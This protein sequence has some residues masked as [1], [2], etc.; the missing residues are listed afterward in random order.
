VTSITSS[1]G[2]IAPDQIAPLL[3]GRMD[4]HQSQPRVISISQSTEF[5]T[6]YSIDEIHTLADFAHANDMKL[7]MDGARLSNATASL[8]CSLREITGEAGVDILSFGGTKNGMMMGEAVIFFR[9]DDAEHFKFIRKQGTHLVSKMRFLSAQFTAFFKDD[10]WFHNASHANN[11]AALLAQ[12]LKTIPQ[13]R[14]VQKVQANAVF[15]TMPE[16]VVEELQKLHF[17]YIFDHEQGIARLM[18]S[19][20]TTER[21]VY[22]FITDLKKLLKRYG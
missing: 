22:R 5:G 13:V 9:P 18:T 6:V 3:Q 2:K 8:G 14:I 4:E 19:F 10:L 12:E 17:F 1:D 15:L 7:H 11:M 16:Q 21:D 20:D